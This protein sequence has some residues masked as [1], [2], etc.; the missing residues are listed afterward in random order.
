M[1]SLQLYGHG[2]AKEYMESLFNHIQNND[3]N[4]AL[5][6]SDKLKNALLKYYV[7]RNIDCQIIHDTFHRFNYFLRNC[8]RPE[9][10]FDYLRNIRNLAKMTIEDPI[11]HLRQLYDDLR[12]EFLFINDKSAERMIDLFDEIRGLQKEIEDRKDTS[13]NYFTTVL[14]DLGICESHLTDLTIF[15]GSKPEKEKL[16]Q[17]SSSFQTLFK[18]IQRVIAP[19]I[20]I[21]LTTS[22]IRK[23]LQHS[24]ISEISEATGH[25][26]EELTNML[27]QIEHEESSQ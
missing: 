4:E 3:I 17:V 13:Y 9:T 22:E 14:Q 5:K 6:T 26:E 20:I 21:P 23:Q 7:T 27:N 19:P 10:L 2:K 1:V 24:T 8:N 18:D 12:H 15:Y 11:E 25:R 16:K